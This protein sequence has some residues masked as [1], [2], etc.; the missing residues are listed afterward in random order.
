MNVLAL[1]FGLKRI[2]L[3]VGSTESGIAFVRDVLMNDADCF[4]SLDAL[5][6]QEH[7]AHILVGMP[8]KRDGASGDIHGELTS[9]LEELKSRYSLPIVLF[10]ER[11]TSK[12]AREKL[13]DLELTKSE[14]KEPIDSFAAQILLQEWLESQ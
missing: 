12:M 14:R 4:Q 9:F 1:D 11:Y 6:D 10:D 2:G 3:S 8:Y 13:K 7:I 5:V